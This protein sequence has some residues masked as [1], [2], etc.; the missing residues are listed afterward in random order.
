[1]KAFLL[2]LVSIT[3]S[4]TASAQANDVEM[5]DQFRAD[6]KIYVVI[7]VVCV[8]LMGL[9]AYLFRLERKVTELEKRSK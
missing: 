1:M 6:G 4:F 9:F 2:L 5:A 8:V 7:A 3:L